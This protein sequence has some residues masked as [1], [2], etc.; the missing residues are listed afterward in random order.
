MLPLGIWFPD[1]IWRRKIWNSAEYREKKDIWKF[2]NHKGAEEYPDEMLVYLEKESKNAAIVV[3][4]KQIHLR[5]ESKYLP[6]IRFQKTDTT[7]RRIILDL[8][9]P[10]GFSVN[11]YI[12]KD[13][14]IGEKVDCISSWSLLIFLLPKVDDLIQLIKQ[15][16]KGCLVYK[17]R[18]S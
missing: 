9:F 3:L 15:K 8:S 18:F 6:S 4:L 13:D 7:E 1:W 5:Q 2:K 11:D 12:S 14:Y 10:V 17:K 16:G